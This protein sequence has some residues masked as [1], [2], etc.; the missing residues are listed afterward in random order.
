MQTR[1][2]RIHD[3]QDLRVE[4]ADVAA[5][6]SGEVLVQIGT[7]G[8]CGSDLHYYHDGGFGPV[9][10]K[11]PMVLGHEVAG[12]VQSIGPDVTGLKPGDRVALNP[13]R[14]CG[15]CEYCDQGLFQHCHEML[16]FG[17]AMRFPHV[18]GAFR[19]R[20]VVKAEQCVPVSDTTE[21]AEAACAEPLSVCLHARSRAPDLKGKRVLVTG[22]GP[23][24]VLCAALA[25]EAGAA[26]IVSTDLQDMPLQVALKMGATRAINVGT[27]PEEMLPYMENKGHFDVAFECSAAAPA[28][29]AAIAALRP[30]GSLVQVGV[31]GEV[32]VPI[33]QLVGKEINFLGTHRF[34]P[35]FKLAVDMINRRVIDV[36]PMV[37]QTYPLEQAI[38][39]FDIAGDRSR[40]VKVHLTFAG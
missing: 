5:P 22:A 33:N 36:R 13:S 18:Q 26:E 20:M 11:E 21:M 15:N 35:E 23:I 3:R 30:Q 2:C 27:N 34:H 16:F 24:G 32:L 9:R 19:D 14:P 39:A 31:T 25:A 28:I 6:H 40:A 38:A 37:T 7:G 4:T 29:H 8:I 12:T 17:S 10:I 1:L